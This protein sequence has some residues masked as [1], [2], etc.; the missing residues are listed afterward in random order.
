VLTYE[1]VPASTTSA[2]GGGYCCLVL[3]GLGD[4][5]YG[6]KPVVPMLGL[7]EVSFV[8]PNAPREYHGGWS[9]FDLHDDLSIE[10]DH[11]RASRAALREL[12][13]HLLERFSITSE[14]LFLMGFSQGCLMALDTALRW[15]SPFAG[16][17]GISGF[18]TML[19]EYPAAFGAAAKSQRILLTHGRYDGMIPITYSRAQKDRLAALGIAVDW[20]EYDKE[21]TLDPTRELA[22]IRAFMR[23]GM[24]ASAAKR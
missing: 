20:R 7:P 4:S 2:S 18:M 14:R 16:V 15:E 24:A 22:D 17:V 21:H 1:T 9:W 5:L 8:L 10:D 11:V 13:A 12:I 23:A 19:D 6:W 3:H